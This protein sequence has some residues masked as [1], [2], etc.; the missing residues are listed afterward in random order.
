[1]DKEFCQIIVSAATKNEADKISDVLV[2]KK[3]V[4]GSLIIKGQSRY[5]WEG[6]IVEREYFNIQAF[7]ILKNKSKIIL[8]VKR[9]HSDNCPIISFSEID[10]NI[11]FL[12]WIEDSLENKK[13]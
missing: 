12:K 7:S 9:I 13:G 5:W 3:L 8:E 2:G 11:E 10:G 6:K 4:A 1:M